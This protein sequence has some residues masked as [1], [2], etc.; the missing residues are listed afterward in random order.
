M[1]LTRDMRDSIRADL[2]TEKFRESRELHTE[3]GF[4]LAMNIFK[5]VYG[6]HMTQIEA[7]PEGWL[8]TITSIRVKFGASF[9]R[10]SL[11]APLAVPND[12]MVKCDAVYEASHKFS[13]AYEKLVNDKEIQAEQRAKLY[14]EIGAVLLS[15]T[16]TAALI[17]AWPEVEPYVKRHTP[18]AVQLPAV[19]IEDLNRNLG[20]GVAT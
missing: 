11:P 17:A 5:D 16:T 9:T 1:R 12:D 15:V 4:K 8:P 19:Q 20:L 18:N 2:L 3:Q 10:L 14:N 13:Q 7:I 6:K